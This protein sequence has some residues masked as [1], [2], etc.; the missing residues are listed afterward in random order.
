MRHHQD[1]RTVITGAARLLL[2][3]AEAI[4]RRPDA[5][6]HALIMDA[7]RTEAVTVEAA[8]RLIAQ[9]IQALG[10]TR[11]AAVTAVV[12]NDEHRDP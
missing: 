6:A 8:R 1:L 7:S 3:P 11:D 2:C 4:H 5:A 10:A 12:V 9:A